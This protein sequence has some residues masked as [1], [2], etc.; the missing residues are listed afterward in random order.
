[1]HPLG[2]SNAKL[3]EKEPDVIEVQTIIRDYPS[4][5]QSMIERTESGS[6]GAYREY[7]LCKYTNIE[8]LLG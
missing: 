1:M 6:S 5:T 4:G 8:K 2:I 7:P 3:K